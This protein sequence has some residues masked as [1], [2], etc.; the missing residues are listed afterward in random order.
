MQ[1]TNLN[2]TSELI[3][4]K[5]GEKPKIVIITTGGT[6]ASNNNHDDMATPALAGRDLIAAVPSLNQYADII[7]HEYSN[8]DSKDMAPDNW[9]QIAKITNNYL[10]NDD[11]EGVV[12]THGT[13]TM[14]YTSFFLEYVIDSRKPVVL[15]GAMLPSNDSS[16]DGPRNLLAAVRVVSSSGTP[17]NLVGVVFNNRVISGLAVKKMHSTN[18]DAFHGGNHGYL[19]NIDNK[20]ITWLNLPLKHKKFT[21]KDKLPRVDII[22][23]YPGVDATFLEAALAK[24]TKGL[25]VVGYGAGN[26]NEAIALGLEPYFANGIPVIIDSIASHGSSLP[27]YG[28]I[29]GGAYYQQKGAIMGQILS[30]GKAR[31]LLMLAL[32]NNVELSVLG[33]YLD[34]IS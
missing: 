27:A 28:G 25:I 9:V 16:P 6:I 19:A 30:P 4:L 21:I 7:I 5:P 33:T 26:T 8:I 13:D 11:I 12:I 31:I 34:Y 18:L 29:G 23:V 10:N 17:D 14:E 24:N 1:K 3:I 32:S 15:T 20:H 2:N 22:N